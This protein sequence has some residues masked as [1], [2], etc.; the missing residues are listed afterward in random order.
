MEDLERGM[1]LTMSDST[2]T[3]THEQEIKAF[4]RALARS[5]DEVIRLRR[6]LLLAES[7]ARRYA[8]FYPQSSDARNT[9]EILADRIAEIAK[10]HQS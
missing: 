2:T 8:G 1:K 7:E 5:E 6:A 4:S 3:L 10:E 9:F